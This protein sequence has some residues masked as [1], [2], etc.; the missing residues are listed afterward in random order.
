MLPGETFETPEKSEYLGFSKAS[1]AE[2]NIMDRQLEKK[3]LN[4]QLKLKMR[5]GHAG[6]K[7]N[8]T[9]QH[10]SYLAHTIT[11]LCF[12]SCF[13]LIATREYRLHMGVTQLETEECKVAVSRG[14]RCKLV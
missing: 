2:A 7:L 4:P 8:E 13:F 3:N 14:H 9:I 1:T 5:D 6:G 11:V 12:A 10:C